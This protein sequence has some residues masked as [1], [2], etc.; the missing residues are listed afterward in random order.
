MNF[1]LKIL[2]LVFVCTFNVCTLSVRADSLEV[3]LLTCSDGDIAYTM[4][5]HTALRVHNLTTGYDM[6][7]NYGMFNLDEDRFV[8]KFVKGETDYILGAEPADYFV[9]RYAERGMGIKEQVLNIT[10]EECLRLFSILLENIQPANRTYRYNWLYDNCTT[11]ARDA[12][13]RALYGCVSYKYKP[14]DVQERAP[15][16]ARQML[17][18]T[19]SYRNRWVEFGQ[20]FV[21]GCEIDRMLTPRE[22]MFLPRQYSL[23]AAM[24]NIDRVEIVDKVDTILGRPIIMRSDTFVRT[25]PLIST[26]RELLPVRNFH[27]AR[28]LDPPFVTFTLLFIITLIVC[29]VELRRRKTFKWVDVIFCVLTGLAGILVSF[30]F[31]FS[32]HAGVDSNAMVIL[33]N[34]LPFLWIPFCIRRKV[35]ILSYAILA[36]FVIFFIAIIAVGQHVD[37][38]FWP[39]VSTLLLRVVVNAWLSNQKYVTLQNIRK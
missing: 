24:S 4:Y 32:E 34:P 15:Q 38:A 3:S 31:F 39:L 10:Q 28:L 17:H 19:A 36:V 26:E 18:P 33:F 5:G 14:D 23:Y 13:E 9:R 30:L 6:V 8:Y 11:R 1:I 2:L 7:F 25:V 20:N 16:S 27:D 37:F 29:V 22:S 12:V 35:R 21:L